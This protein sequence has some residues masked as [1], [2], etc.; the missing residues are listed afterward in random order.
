M[1]IPSTLLAATSAAA[2]PDMLGWVGADVV[3]LLQA[4]AQATA[5]TFPDTIITKQVVAEPGALERAA[6]A[7]RALMTLAIVVLTFAVVPAAWNF[8]KSYQK[9]SDIL[10]RVYADVTP[11]AHHASRIAEN[12]DYVSSAVR[13]DVQRVSEMVADAEARLRHAIGRAEQRARELEALL[14]VAQGEAEE[15]FVSTASA[16]RGV[17]AGVAALRGDLTAA[18]RAAASEPGGL[19]REAGPERAA[20]AAEDLALADEREA[21]RPRGVSRAAGV[22]DDEFDDD[23]YLDYLDLADEEPDDAY[24]D[25]ADDAPE[26]P[27]VRPRRGRRLNDG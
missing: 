22:L 4:A 11:I 21:A 14:D 9:V 2:L 13:S 1:L 6:Q 20:D 8:R 5:R 18:R 26:R 27:R 24:P 23:L 25:R 19:A 17:R 3:P 16:V 12:V 15:T 10:D 7:L